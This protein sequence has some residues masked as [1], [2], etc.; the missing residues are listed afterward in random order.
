MM[1]A[2]LHYR[3]IHISY[4]FGLSLMLQNRETECYSDNLFGDFISVKRI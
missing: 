1:H 2:S 4:E 3:Q